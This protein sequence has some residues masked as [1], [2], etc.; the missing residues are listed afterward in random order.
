MIAQRDLK[1][2]QKA[3]L[4]FRGRGEKNKEVLQTENIKYDEGKR[5]KTFK[6][7]MDQKVNLLY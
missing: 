2:N 4:D 3:S 5:Y 6:G 1:V 7:Q